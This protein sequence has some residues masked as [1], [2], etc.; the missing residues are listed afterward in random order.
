M[1]TKRDYYE[2]LGLRRDAG[3]DEV[4]KAYRQL[5]LKYHP[6]KNP[7]DLEA[8]KKFKEPAEAYEALSD[9]AT[10]RRPGRPVA[11][12]LPDGHHLPGLRRRGDAGHRPL[13]PVPRRRQGPAARAAPGRHPRRGRHRHVAPAPQPGGA[14]RPGRAAGQPADPA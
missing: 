13:P 7:R 10:R 8:E 4:K 12:L 1:A 5:A 3:A 14:R 11:R 6:D 2:V 9:P